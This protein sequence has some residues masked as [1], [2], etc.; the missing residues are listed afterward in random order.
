MHTPPTAWKKSRSI[1]RTV[2][3]HDR[4]A[5]KESLQHLTPTFAKHIRNDTGALDVAILQHLL[6]AIFRLG[7]CLH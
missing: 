6:D 5:R 3:V 2:E 1:I 7:P 4:F